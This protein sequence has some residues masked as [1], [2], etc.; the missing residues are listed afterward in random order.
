MEQN[1]GKTFLEP[2][3]RV[4]VA[5]CDKA[6]DLCVLG[7]HFDF[8][9]GTEASCSGSRQPVSTARGIRRGP[10]LSHQHREQGEARAGQKSTESSQGLGFR[11]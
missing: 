11:V 3:L 5:A 9:R 2:E 10:L 6:S 1:G 7:A 8:E 4:W